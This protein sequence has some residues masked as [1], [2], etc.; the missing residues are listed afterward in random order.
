MFNQERLVNLFKELCLINAPSKQERACADYLLNLFRQEGIEVTEDD[1]GSKIGGNCGNLVAKIPG[2]VPGAKTIFLSAH[3][4]T[5]EPTAGLKI[6]EENGVFRTDGTTILGAD[7]KGGLAP[8]IEAVRTLKEQNLQHGTIYLLISIAEEIG[9]LG[10]HHLNIRELNIDFGYVL[11]TGPPVG[12]FVTKTA[13]HDKI[14]VR[15]VGKPAH[16]GKDPEKGVSAIQV[17]AEA[18]HNMKLGR[19]GPETTAN[20]G[21]I[22]GGSAVNVV[23]A[24]VQIRGE[25]RSTSVEELDAQVGH[26]V[27]C[28]E[29]ACASMGAELHIDHERHYGAYCIEESEP[30]VQV[31]LKASEHIQ[32]PTKLRTTLGGSDANVY[33][34][35][36]L[37]CVVVAT[38][39]DQ[40]HT[41]Q[42]HISIKDLCDTTDLVIRL[43]LEAAKV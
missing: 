33:N 20:L 9:L 41:H 12:S 27:H 35:K 24:E 28:F 15:I 43:V 19:I 21:L 42:E 6:I 11:D 34:A 8:I 36:G 18:I 37:P 14:D 3:M 16:S 40:I 29:Q 1:A 10:A 4:D 32:L 2:N 31:A 17:A 7:D 30:V 39:M 26:M 13:T 5:V 22:S 25:A 38:G 23:A